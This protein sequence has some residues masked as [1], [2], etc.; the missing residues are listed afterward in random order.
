M[1]VT[2]CGALNLDIIYEIDNLERIRQAGFPLEPGRE[3]TLSH[4]RAQE[5]LELLEKTATLMGKSGGGSAANTLCALAKMGHRSYF[6]GTVGD[7]PEGDFLLDS[8]KDVDCSLVS[9][10]GRS[11]ICI[12]VIDG[13]SNDRAM[14]VVPGTLKIDFDNPKM[15]TVLKNTR[16]FHMSSLVQQEGPSLQGRVLELCTKGCLVTFDPGEIYAQKGFE[17]IKGL[18]AQTALLFASDVEF[19][20]IFQGKSIM[21]VL[22]KKFFGKRIHPKHLISYKFFKDMPPPVIAKK[23]GAE[24]ALLASTNL[25]FK[26]PAQKVEKIVDNT[27]AGDAF[28]AGLIDAIFKNKDPK[29]A[30]E[31]AVS[32]AAFS[33]MFTGRQWIDHLDGF[34][35]LPP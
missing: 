16:L 23:A 31:E 30:L 27:G 13:L 9:Q 1:I 7:D 3:C 14:A 17:A 29:T 33:L 15:E 6:I 19:Q 24:G 34:A 21:E 35:I 22:T 2:G 10:C 11:S 26:C 12:I 8:M 32:T 20:T 25:I 5:L 4:Q 18:L 28:N